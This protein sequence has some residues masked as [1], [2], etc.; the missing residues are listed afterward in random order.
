MNEFSV[1]MLIQEPNALWVIIGVCFLAISTSCIGTFA[2]LNRQSLIGD[3]M[4]HCA[5]PGIAIAFL[6]SQSRHPF[7]LLPVAIASSILG[8]VLLNWLITRTNSVLTLP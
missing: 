4:A 5:L 6:F 3:A 1:L 8:N 7:I 2:W